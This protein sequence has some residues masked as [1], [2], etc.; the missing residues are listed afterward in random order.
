MYSLLQRLNLVSATATTGL[1]VLLPLVMFS[2]WL[3]MPSVLPTADIRVYDV[4][5]AHGSYDHNL[6][7][8]G[9]AWDHVFASIDLDADL[10]PLFTW[11]TKQLFVNLVAEYD[12]KM[13]T[14]NQVTVWDTIVRSPAEAKLKLRGQRRKY[15]LTDI[16]RHITSGQSMNLTLHWSLM[17]WVGVMTSGQQSGVGATFTLPAAEREK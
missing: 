11:N 1:L 7:K 13:H 9:A 10:T 15:I 4:Q 17:P 8:G 16:R 14:G 5:V 2:A 6:Y 3:K 12:T